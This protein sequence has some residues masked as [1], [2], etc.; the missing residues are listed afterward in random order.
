MKGKMDQ[1]NI[2]L[3][4]CNWAPHAAFQ[5]LQDTGE[6]ILAETKMIR[7][8]CTG[9]ISK[10]LLIK[11]FEMGADGVAL[12]GCSHGACRYGTGTVT[13]RENTKDI[14]DILELLGVGR[15]RMRFETFLPD[16]SEKLLGF[17]K[18]FIEEIKTLGPTPICLSRSYE[19]ET[20]LSDSVKKVIASHNITSCQDCGKC[21][22]ACPLALIGKDFSPRTMAGSILSGNIDSDSVKNDI[23]TCLTCGLCYDRCPSAVDFPRFI[24]D[25]RCLLNK[26]QDNKAAHGGFFQS[27]MRTMTSPHLKTKHWNWLPEDIQINPKGKTL[28]FGGCAPYFDIFFRK[29]LDI[30]TSRILIDSL[31]LLNFFDIQPAVLFE[32]RCCGH[33]LLWSGDKKNFMELA[34]LNVNALNDLE[35]EEVITSCPE[36]YRTL[37]HDYRESGLE[38]NFKVTHIYEFLEK[39]IDKGSVNFKKMDRRLTL[40]DSCRLSRFE[41][42]S[43]L[44]RKLINHLNSNGFKEMQF[45]GKAAIC[46]GNCAWTGCDSY[47]KALQVERLKQVHE[48]KSDLLITSCPKCQIH[49]KCAMEDPFLGKDLAI[50]IMDLTS[51]IAK[52]IHW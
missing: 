36:C 9:R 11:A 50:E 49:F 23:W 29:F 35:I 1:L 12:I 47:S 26:K 21:T 13:A 44:P 46:C 18:K 24:R 38:M 10:S 25:I 14:S 16:E 30:D 22:S 43:D 8:P 42:K 19:T 17:L 33:D 27:L 5:T 15:P 41:D 40:Q 20:D 37:S 52:T 28:Y 2:I 31:R 3:F 7:I 45:K 48:T 6:A 39:E 32:E 34:K 51:V 4:L